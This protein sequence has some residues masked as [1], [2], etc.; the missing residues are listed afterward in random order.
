MWV[1]PLIQWSFN[2]DVG[3]LLQTPASERSYL[4]SVTDPDRVAV[5]RRTFGNR[6]R[7]LRVTAGLTQE[8]LAL[9]AGLDRSFYVE[10][11]TGKHSVLL[12]R[13]FDIAEALNVPAS[14][15]LADV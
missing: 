13:V 14:V 2:Q 4:H 8:A 12:D 6:L 3:L 11:E 10:I 9:A 1:S 7:Q 5:R 15:L